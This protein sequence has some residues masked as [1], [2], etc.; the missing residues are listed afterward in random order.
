MRKSSLREHS[1]S[2]HTAYF[3]Y[4]LLTAALVG[5][6]ARPASAGS[7]CMYGPDGSVV[8]RPEGAEC[9]DVAQ[10]EGPKAADFAPPRPTR[11]GAWLEIR[12]GDEQLFEVE[13]TTGRS[14]FGKPFRDTTYKGT[15]HRAVLSAPERF[16][17][18][19]MERRLTLRVAESNQTLDHTDLQ[20]DFIRPTANGYQLLAIN[21]F[22]YFKRQDVDYGKGSILLPA[23]I[24]RGAKWISGQIHDDLFKIDET[25]EV[26]EIQNV[27][28]PA[29]A[30][31]NCLHVRYTGEVGSRHKR[32]DGRSTVMGRFVR[33]AWYA[34]GVGLVREDEEGRLEA[35][36][37]G[38][39]F[40][41]KWK[42][43]AAIKGVK[44]AS[45][46]AKQR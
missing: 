3:R 37:R 43:S 2:N 46:P 20:R 29:G 17:A 14:D 45:L 21:R 15:Q 44:R 32:L 24:A 5:A 6:A 34:R 26:I 42:W 13:A 9:R 18:G 23:Q 4:L 38:D 33:D 39:S 7:A 16:G 36:W 22:W 35:I 31:E 27:V 10:P 12:P 25:G 30:L 28:T 11:D 41:Y 19:G 1:L 8:Y 40:A